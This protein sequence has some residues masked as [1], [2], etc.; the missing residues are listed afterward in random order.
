MENVEE[1]IPAFPMWKMF[2]KTVIPALLNMEYSDIDL[3]T[4]TNIIKTTEF[5]NIF[6]Y[7][8]DLNTPLEDYE[9]KSKNYKA[10]TV[11]LLGRFLYLLSC[12]NLL[13]IHNLVFDA[14]VRILHYINMTQPVTYDELCD[15][16]ISALKQLNHYYSKCEFKQESEILK[17]FE[18]IY[19][20]ELEDT[21]DLNLLSINITSKADCINMQK[22]LIKLIYE[23]LLQN[24]EKCYYNDVVYESLQCLQFILRE[25]NI[26]LKLLVLEV[27]VD[28]L[29]HNQI[30]PEK[31]DEKFITTFNNFIPLLEILLYNVYDKNYVIAGVHLQQLDTIMISLFIHFKN[32]DGLKEKLHRIANYLYSKTSNKKLQSASFD[33]MQSAQTLHCMDHVNECIEKVINNG[34][35]HLLKV[36]KKQILYEIKTQKISKLWYELL[37][38]LKSKCTDDLKNVHCT[39]KCPLFEQVT[40]IAKLAETVLEL[41]IESHV[42]ELDLPFF[43]NVVQNLFV[44]AFNH[45][46]V[47]KEKHLVGTFIQKLFIILPEVA[48]LEMVFY[49]FAHSFNNIVMALKS[50]KAA[51]KN[52][53]ISRFLNYKSITTHQDALMYLC[54]FIHN[55]SSKLTQLLNAESASIRNLETD[56]MEIVKKCLTHTVQGLSVKDLKEVLQYP[57]L[58]NTRDQWVNDIICPALQTLPS[59][60]LPAVIEASS[61]LICQSN[62]D[63]LQI[64]S[65]NNDS[66]VII[67]NHCLTCQNKFSYTNKYDLKPILDQMQETKMVY[68][69]FAPV[70]GNIDH[71]F[72]LLMIITL[73]NHENYEVKMAIIKSL[74]SFTHIPSLFQAEHIK[75]WI[76]FANDSN[77]NIRFKFASVI[78]RIFNAVKDSTMLSAEKKEMIVKSCFLE[79][80]NISKLS[81]QFSNFELQETVLETINQLSK[82]SFNV[83]TR[84]VTQVLLY[85]IMI[86]T[87]KYLLIATDIFMEMANVQGI[88]T[89]VIYLQ[90][91]KQLCQNIMKMCAI[92][93]ALIDYNL[94]TSL[95]NIS[96][97]LGFYGSKDFLMKETRNLLP[98]LISLI[99]TMP[100]IE[101]LVEEYASL[102][103]ISLSELVTTRYGYIFLHL[104]LNESEDTFKKLMN[105]IEKCTGCSG[106]SLRK[107]DFLV[108]LNELLLNFHEKR[109]RVLL[110]LRILARDDLEGQTLSV[111]QIPEY[112]NP[113]LLGVL[114]YF[115]MKLTARHLDKTKVLLSLAELVTFM[116]PKFITPLRFKI[117]AMLKTALGAKS[118]NCPDLNCD[119]WEAFL[120][121]CEIDA[122]GPQLASIFVSLLPL[123]QKCPN[124]VTSIFKYL[125]IRNEA[126]VEDHICDLFFV[127]ESDVDIEICDV[128]RKYLRRVENMP[129]KDQLKSF[130]KYLNYETVDIRVYGLKYIKRLLEKNREEVDQMI[131]GY[132]GIDP[133]IVDLLDI[134]MLAC[135]EKEDAIKLACGECIGELGAIDPSHLPR[136]Y[137]NEVKTFVFFITENAFIV[138]AL[139]ELGRALQAEKNTHNVDRFALAIQ[140]ILKVYGISSDPNSPRHNLWTEFS[141]SQQ[142]LMLPLLSSRYTMVQP[143]EK[144]CAVPIYGSKHGSSFNTWVSNWAC[145]LILELEADNRSLLQVC[146]PSLKQDHKTLMTFLPHILLHALLDGD[147]DVHQNIYEEF[148]A[149]I[150]SFSNRETALPILNIKPLPNGASLTANPI[151]PEEKVIFVILDFLDRWIREWICKRGVAS[152]NDKE[153]A[154]INRFLSQFCKL[155]LAKANY[156][157]G[158][159]ARSLMYIEEY[160]KEQPGDLTNQFSFLTELYAQLDEPDGV[161]GVTAMQDTEP[162]LEQRL[163]A[164][165]VSGKLADAIACYEQIPPPLKP[166]HIQ[167]LIQCY[168]DLDNVNTA[169]NFARGAMWTQ[170]ECTTLLLET[171]AEPLWRLSRYTDLDNLLE[172]E[173]LKNNHSWSVDMG[174]SLLYLQNGKNDEFNN[175]LNMLSIAQVELLGAASLKEGAY[176]RGYSYVARLHAINELKQ[177]GAMIQ[178]LC[179]RPNDHKVCE[180]VIKKLM[181]E[182]ELRL[183]VVQESIRIQEPILCLRRVG[184]QQA[185]Q[186]L[187]EKVAPSLPLLNSI[188]GEAWLQSAT[189]ARTAGV[190]QQAFT[191]TLKADEYKPPRLFLEKAKLHWLREEHEQALSTLQRGLEVLAPENLNTV[192][193]SYNNLNSD[194]RK[195]L[196][197]VKLLI[198][199]YNDAVS[200]VETDVNKQHYKDAIDVYNQWE[201][202]LVCLAQYY[203]RIFQTLP[204]T[205]K[206]RDEIGIL[207]INYFGRSLLY[208]SEFIYQS[209]PRMLSIWFDY[210]TDVFNLSSGMSISR[211]GGRGKAE[212]ENT[213]LQMTKLIDTFLDRLPAYIFLT[214]FSQ[215]V[216]RI[217]HPQKQVYMELK[218]IIV[219]LILQYPQQTLWMLISV[220]KSRCTVRS[221]RCSEILSDGRLKTPAMIKLIGDFTKLAEKLIE[222]CN[223]EIPNKVKV[224]YVSSLSRSLPRLLTREDFSEIM[225]PTQKFRKLI[226]P[227]P[228]FQNS[229]HNPFP[230]HYVHI[231]GIEDEITI[232]QSLQTPRKIT[233]KGSDGKKYTQMLKP[234]DD[235]RKD[236][237]LM[238]FNDVV[239]QM[240]SRDPAS[241]QRRL[242]IRLYSVVPLNEECGLLE[243]IPDLI[244]FRPALVQLYK[245]RGLG[246]TTKELTQMFCDQ[247]DSLVKKR[248]VFTKSLLPKHPPILNEWFRKTFPD[249][250]SWLTAR[251]AYIRTTAAISMVG[252]ILGLGDRHG[253]NILFD[254]TCGDTVHVDF[255]C[256]FNKGETL[257]WPERVPFRLTQNMVAAMGPLGVEGVFR[258]SCACTLSVLRA[259]IN[260]LMSIVTPFVYDPLVSWSKKTMTN[261]NVLI[262]EQQNLQAVEHIG[263]IE[264]RLKGITKSRKSSTAIPLSVDGQ[265]NNLILEAMSIDNLCQMYIG[266]GAYL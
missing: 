172:K 136:Q 106:K 242:H 169:L 244:G 261:T 8:R 124:K 55:V 58:F 29:K 234:K 174:R 184:I 196:A 182:W 126:F 215:I 53:R 76:R 164:L 69:I 230:N 16:Y 71:D 92:N 212:K 258:K 155:R 83:I 181:S 132:N 157:C 112:L 245:E 193:L 84:Y 23:I 73:S 247:K 170:P 141:E 179:I 9:R 139:N 176:Q 165:E 156:Q 200:N 94:L 252:Y 231:V 117:L 256:L 61:D 62:S 202:S 56:Y 168:L 82:V 173:E 129:F 49:S 148:M 198:A 127:L 44:K 135:R 195:I 204:E 239:N 89:N 108:I 12:D 113:K 116:G 142:E 144:I 167:C 107:K 97:V 75:L 37:N 240:L 149:V 34:E 205:E 266:W 39:D 77:K 98:T 218:S 225:I 160:I 188:L 24:I 236:F 46:E 121:S 28:L 175:A 35:Y 78:S 158:E 65:W 147:A 47:C 40:L 64:V 17:V 25:C 262:A 63:F 1:N 13:K 7:A 26:E 190:H 246:L 223:I 251:T 162:P 50:K 216:S 60:L 125:I 146:L 233:F 206:E 5:S 43:D 100:K 18:P 163:L 264:Q 66:N 208:G 101:K 41:K 222:L 229:Q 154:I 86:P 131:L 133:T 213:L 68:K 219:K 210:G 90:Y 128:I 42:P 203:D 91:K 263:N 201:K 145:N 96:L 143:I 74:P 220:I 249:P 80:E 81:L 209:M 119:V 199:S 114:A 115:D 151:S 211:T 186:L 254:S 51:D 123:L 197:E 87:S 103:E 217:C 137:K 140:E 102:L 260:T 57:L 221:R 187:A 67:E 253:E 237:R 15:E 48:D 85:F 6:V 243:W 45:Y 265:T 22:R 178:E 207:M 130:L 20:K 10:F 238:E 183:K 21:L 33:Y 99:V 54:R 257:Q 19:T 134:L 214:A 248:E 111:N 228:D 31:N 59:H 259:H 30:V 227:N 93:H 122:L 118:G 235:L 120:K 27:H 166:H 171:Q 194:N 152:T 79:L 52:I 14:Q 3:Q 226:L 70:Q 185:K 138:N 161:A 95:E 191:Y 232:L 110:G 88:N 250:Q 11:W 177:I 36:F 2:N 192:T 105:Y 150:N 104:F 255:N 38:G 224:T 189:I 72:L 32:S 180:T 241:R 159:Y 4:L 153:Y 109:D